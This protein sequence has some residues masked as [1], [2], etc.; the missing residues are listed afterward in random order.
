VPLRTATKMDKAPL[1]AAPR[2]VRWPE[3]VAPA[4][5]R[6]APVCRSTRWPELTVPTGGRGAPLP[7]A[8][9]R[10]WADREAAPACRCEIHEGDGGASGQRLDRVMKEKMIRLFCGDRCHKYVLQAHR[11]LFSSSSELLM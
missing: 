10:L 8:G 11:S 6:G 7:T 9:G 3:L 5:G 2:W 1:R 4:G